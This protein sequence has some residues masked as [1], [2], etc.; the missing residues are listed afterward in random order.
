[1][2]VAK[3]LPLLLIQGLGGMYEALEDM[4]RRNGIRSDFLH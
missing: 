3:A 2:K 4:F 1:M